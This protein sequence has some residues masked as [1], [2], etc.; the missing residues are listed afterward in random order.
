MKKIILDMMNREGGYVNHPHDLGGPTNYG[1]TLKTYQRVKPG[2]TIDDLK[3]MTFNEAYSI[4]EEEYFYKPKI[5]L[6]EYH[7]V[8]IAEKILDCGVNMGHVTAIRF[9]QD[10][11]NV[12]NTVSGR[13]LYADL[14]VDGVIGQKTIDALQKYL[15]ARR[16]EGEIVLLKAINSLQ[17]A[18]YISITKSRTEN[19]SF[20]YGWLN[21]RIFF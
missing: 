16:R 10:S 17:G 1:I 19:K 15:Q 2:S 18:Y 13:A 14:Y 7:S 20:I 5:N 8:D 6:L 21:Q 4:Y 9:L 11:L 3:R 12:L